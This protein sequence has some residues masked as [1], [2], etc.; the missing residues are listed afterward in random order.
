VFVLPKCFT[1]LVFS[2]LKW[3]PVAARA[4]QVIHYL[5]EF[6]AVFDA[7]F[8]AIETSLSPCLIV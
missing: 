3:A 5:V 1:L 6:R 2:G 7:D 8:P 4:P